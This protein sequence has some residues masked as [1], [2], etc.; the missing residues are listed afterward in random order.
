MRTSNI[1]YFATTT[2]ARLFGLAFFPPREMPPPRACP[3]DE[4][5]ISTGSCSKARSFIR[6]LSIL[7][8]DIFSSLR[9]RWPLL[10]SELSAIRRSTVHCVTN[11]NKARTHTRHPSVGQDTLHHSNSPSSSYNASSTNRSASL[12]LVSSQFFSLL[13][14]DDTND[15]V[16]I[17]TYDSAIAKSRPVHLTFLASC[18]RS[19]TTGA[20][21]RSSGI[22]G[23]LATPRDWQICVW[24]SVSSG[25]TKDSALPFRPARAVRPERCT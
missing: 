14:C 25:A 3:T 13:F 12:A 11:S 16:N 20:A 22:V 2:K 5:A 4:D 24:W 15:S 17:C 21:D 10:F 7:F 6:S 19:F 9:C 1:S 8:L 18:T 23:K